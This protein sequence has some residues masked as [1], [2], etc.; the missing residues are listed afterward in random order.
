MSRWEELVLREEATRQVRA[1]GVTEPQQTFVASALR[2]AAEDAG[3]VTT[4]CERGL[5]TWWSA[6]S[7]WAR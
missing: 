6:Y 1:A 2:L 5:L 3:V 7:P 4:D